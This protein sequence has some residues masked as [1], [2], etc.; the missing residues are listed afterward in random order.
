MP[1]FGLSTFSKAI[2]GYGDIIPSDPRATKTIVARLIDPETHDYVAEGRSFQET[3]PVKQRILIALTSTRG[4]GAAVPEIGLNI[5]AG[6]L[7]GKSFESMIKDNI[8]RSLRQITDVEKKAI[9][10]DL[11]VSKDNF[12]VFITL[13]FI[14]LTSPLNTPEFL[15]LPLRTQ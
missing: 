14:D 11:I 13:G 8:R 5:P 2:F 3:T 9:I 6:A 7:M 10:T 12:R 4:S 15:K 1:G